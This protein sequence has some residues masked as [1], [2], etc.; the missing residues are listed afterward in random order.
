M[1]VGDIE[2]LSEDSCRIEQMKLF[3]TIVQDGFHRSSLFPPLDH[4]LQGANKA[5]LDNVAN[6]VPDLID[7]GKN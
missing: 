2:A 3:R 4:P 6:A 7:M 1:K 5:V